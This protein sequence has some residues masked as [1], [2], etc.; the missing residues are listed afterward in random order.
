MKAADL[1]RVKAADYLGWGC[2]M[3]F[4]IG[5]FVGTFLMKFIKP[6]RLLGLYAVLNTILCVAAMTLHGLPAV[7]CVIGI[8]FFMSIMFPTIFSLG[9]ADL[10]A[11]TEW[12]AV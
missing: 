11:D 1:D 5:R 12:E 7:Y 3:A 9:I 10:D 8:A 4:M 2:G 6:A